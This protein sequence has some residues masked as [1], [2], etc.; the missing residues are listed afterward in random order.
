MEDFNVLIVALGVHC[1]I[2]MSSSFVPSIPIPL[3]NFAT[4]QL[5]FPLPVSTMTVLTSTLRRA[6]RWR[7]G[8]CDLLLEVGQKISMSF[9]LLFSLVKSLL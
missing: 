1:S 9:W 6:S 3:T 8:V 5:L 4:S 2:D 7:A